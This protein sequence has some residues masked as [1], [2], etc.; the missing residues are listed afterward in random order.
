MLFLKE[1]GPKPVSNWFE[2]GLEPVRNWFGTGL[3]I[4]IT[5]KYQGIF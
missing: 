5:G 1:I 2:T 3:E 4:N